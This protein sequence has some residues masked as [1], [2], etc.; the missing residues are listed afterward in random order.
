MLSRGVRYAKKH[1][2]AGQLV[3]A[4]RIEDEGGEGKPAI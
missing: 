3:T 2:S 1:T 4:R